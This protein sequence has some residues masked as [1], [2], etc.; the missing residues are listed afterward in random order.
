M[1]NWGVDPLITVL[2][3]LSVGGFVGAII[4]VIG[5]SVVSFLVCYPLLLFYDWSKTDWLGIEAAKSLKEFDGKEGGWFKRMVAKTLR[6]GDPFAVIAMSIF[7]DAFV[8][9][10]YMRHGANQYNGLTKRD[11]V[12]F[13]SSIVISSISETVVLYGGFELIK[14]GWKMFVG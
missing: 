3:N 11:W 9:V 6:F 7:T 13:V 12:I 2:A 14:Q 4:A 10:A 8:V 1:I 5:L